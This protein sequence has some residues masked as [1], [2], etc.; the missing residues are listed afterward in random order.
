MSEDKKRFYRTKLQADITNLGITN[1]TLKCLADRWDD[2]AEEIEAIMKSL[3]EFQALL[4]TEGHMGY[5]PKEALPV[6]IKTGAEINAH[7]EV[8]KAA[9]LA[10]EVEAK[11]LATEKAKAE[12]EAVKAEKAKLKAE[13]EANAKA[14]KAIADKHNA[15]VKAAKAKLAAQVKAQKKAELEAQIAELEE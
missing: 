7:N 5:H 2:R 10:L 3:Q 6:V 12:K 4:R 14:E 1:L 8:V 11:R 9:E 15:E 13:Q